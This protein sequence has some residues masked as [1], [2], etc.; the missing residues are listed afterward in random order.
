MFLAP[1]LQAGA[2]V[3][4]E[5]RALLDDGDRVLAKVEAVAAT[6]TPSGPADSKR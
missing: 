5:G 2:R 3:V 1:D 6:S 4:T